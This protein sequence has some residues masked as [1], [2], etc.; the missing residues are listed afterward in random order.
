MLTR[1]VTQVILYWA[2]G[3]PDRQL[4]ADSDGASDDALPKNDG[5]Q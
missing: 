5:Q 3:S 2:R 1:D 4:P